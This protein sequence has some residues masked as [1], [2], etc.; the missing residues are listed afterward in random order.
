VGI[1]GREIALAVLEKALLDHRAI[2]SGETC[3]RNV[4][5]RRVRVAVVTDTILGGRGCGWFRTGD[6]FPV[7]SSG[8]PNS[9]TGFS[10]GSA[11]C[12]VFE[13]GASAGVLVSSRSTPSLLRPRPWTHGPPTSRHVEVTYSPPCDRTAWTAR[14]GAAHDADIVEVIRAPAVTPGGGG[15]SR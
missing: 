4:R 9:R 11:A 14:H 8:R 10:R 5:P 13:G 2:L 1:E 15:T 3:L 7:E 6:R 12:L